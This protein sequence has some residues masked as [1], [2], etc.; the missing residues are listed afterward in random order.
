MGIIYTHSFVCKEQKFFP[1]RLFIKSLYYK[2]LTTI[3][4]K[5]GLTPN[6]HRFVRTYVNEDGGH[7]YLLDSGLNGRVDFVVF[8]SVSYNLVTVLSPVVLSFPSL[9]PICLLFV[10]R[11]FNDVV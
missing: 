5:S 1:R 6:L 9:E 10:L 11:D 7:F 2:C 4:T 3:V 8:V